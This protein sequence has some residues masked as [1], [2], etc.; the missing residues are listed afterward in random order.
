MADNVSEVSA[1]DWIRGITLSVVASIIGGASK[2]SIRK[3]WLIYHANAAR[4]GQQHHNVSICRSFKRL[5]FRGIR[6]AYEEV[7]SPTNSLHKQHYEE[8]EP[9]SPPQDY[10]NNTEIESS[11]N[12]QIT[13]LEVGSP[14]RG[15]SN[16]NGLLQ[17][18]SFSN[19]HVTTPSDTY[20]FNQNDNIPY[21]NNHSSTNTNL[22]SQ[23]QISWLLYL[24][25]MIGMS[26]LNPIACV[27]AMKYASPSILAPFSGLT[28]VWVVLFSGIV[29]NEHPGKS[30]KIACSLIV[31]GEVLV[32]M[33]G[34]HTNG[35]DMNVTDVVSS[36]H[37]SSFHIF[38]I[39]M[40]LYL[41][42][43]SIFIWVFPK[44]SLLKKVAWGS[45]S[46]TITGLQNFL[47]D[48]LTIYQLANNSNKNNNSISN[49]GVGSDD[50]PT[51]FFLFVLLAMAT[52]FIGLL[53]LA[54]CMKRYDATYSAA[55]FVT[56]F[57]LSASIMSCVH[58]HTFQHLDGAI[59]YFMYPIGLSTLFMGAFILVKPSTVTS[60][61]HC[62]LLSITDNDDDRDVS[63]SDHNNEEV[64]NADSY[65]ERLLNEGP[66][67]EI[68]L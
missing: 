33:F 6:D 38:I 62:L 65:R 16:S 18:E 48:A 45:I 20:F 52:S 9:Q 37:E 55:M 34:D 59:N 21:N 23:S 63:I 13:P 3:S 29:L 47:K 5:L 14:S 53:C 17:D 12:Q 42:Q 4:R 35:E 7:F 10:I 36:Y 32:A 43:L 24:C 67:E 49:Y 1:H 25:G 46:G 66:D 64:G 68:V 39:F 51:I 26:F 40:I 57:V 31:L 28:L 54:S 50:L 8:E 58:Y 56:S 30:Q 19:D 15:Q 22:L 61:S 11:T 2:L 27:L 41:I 60:G 44:N